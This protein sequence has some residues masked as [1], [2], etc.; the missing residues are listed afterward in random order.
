MRP[1]SRELPWSDVELMT[2]PLLERERERARERVRKAGKGVKVSQPSRA[3]AIVARQ[4]GISYGQ[5]YKI[6]AIV[7]AAEADPVRFGPLRDE[8]DAKGKLDGPYTKLKR[9]HDEA[10]VLGLVPAVG[11]FRTLVCDPPWAEDNISESAGHDYALMSLAE[12]EAVPIAEWAEEHCHLYLWV[13][14]NTILLA[15]QLLA[16]WGFQHK[17]VHTWTKPRL[18]RGRYFR[19]TTE[20]VIFAVRGDLRTRAP[21]RATRTNHAW[22]VGENSV[23]PEG[24]YDL[25]RA[26]SYP[27][28]GE[29]FQRTA[30]PDFANLYQPAPMIEA[31]E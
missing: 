22:P 18:G 5:L 7:R 26:C 16:A 10:R 4:V 15:P 17:T 12:I 27:P 6:Q 8:M 25:V 9:A 11:R 28:Y 19:N 2:R 29:A 31:A 23:K 13:T 14:N 1:G 21:A 30:R 20:H 24:F 3:M